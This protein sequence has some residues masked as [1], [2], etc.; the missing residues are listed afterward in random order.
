MIETF[1]G[2][3]QLDT[4]KASFAALVLGAAFGFVLERAGFG[5]SRRLAGI[6]YFRDMTVLKVMFTA[7]ITAMLGLSVVLGMGWIAMDQ[8]YLL[9]TIY[10]AQVLGG[11]LFGVGF[12][13][14]GWCPGTAAVG[15]ASGKLDALVFLG[16]SV[17]GAVGFNEA[18]GLLAGLA[19]WGQ[20]EEPLVAF[21]LNRTAFAL[22]FTLVAIGAFHFAEWVE[23]RAARRDAN[24]ANP[25]LQGLSLAFAAMAVALFLLPA[26]PQAAARSPVASNLGTCPGA[27]SGKK[28]LLANV[29]AAQDHLEPEE[30]ADRLMQGGEGLVVVDVRPA[31]E[32]AA[33]H[34]PGAV[35][36]P[37]AEVP[38]YLAPY[39]NQGM[40]VIYSH[41]M[42]HAA[43]ARDELAR[44]GFGNAYLLTDGLQ[45][46]ADRVLKPASLR[47]EPLTPQQVQ[48]IL[49]WRQ[50]FLGMARSSTAPAAPV[51]P[52]ADR[53]PSKPPAVAVTDSPPP[54]VTP[55]W[56]AA[57]L[58][59]GKV[60]VIDV[61]PQPEYNSGHIPG[62]LA[63]HVES[64]R[65][66]AG[67]LSSMLLP[68]DLL[69]RHLSL[70]GVRPDDTV[71]L[72]PGEVRDATLIGMG[73]SRAGHP[74]WAIL[75]G[76]F[77]RWSAEKRT[78]DQSLPA[79]QPTERTGPGRSDGFTVDAAEVLAASKDGE[80][81]I[82][83]VRP[84]DYFRGEKS[85]EARAGH[86]PGAVN[87]P[88]KE[89]LDK[90]GQLKPAEELAAA[91]A[92]IIPGKDAPV[93]VH[94]RTGH[95][96]SQTWFVLA[97]LLGYS[98]VKW[99]DGSWT[100]WAARP[101]L[102]VARP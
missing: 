11:L 61:R 30:L 9:P 100:Q 102:P 95:Q 62:S 46:F 15:A 82:L 18:Y 88:F 22:G 98:N 74:R 14:S 27:C 26:Q 44:Q 52:V 68:A 29:E 40:I 79:I 13:A 69:A 2:M 37:L 89:D 76:G 33:Y 101:E 97:R 94:C 67:G 24:P 57:N 3:D 66:V 48:K 53:G 23:R 5:S 55:K 41:G 34:L 8:I 32:F 47:G 63:L 80:T 60:R 10:G 19:T 31:T 39:K 51:L 92:K 77:A 83:D 16:G 81:I 36:V 38:S 45:G 72:V 43:Q 7:V 50:H 59:K 70:M 96:A 64:F 75:E 71:V 20:H 91:Y 1:F 6:F 58:G 28:S 93:I 25:V 86:I 42:T 65:G 87:R 73:L 21:G 90:S 99:Y 85:D 49:A 56:L 17:L 12:V 54:L 4:P 84:A 35:N 78:V